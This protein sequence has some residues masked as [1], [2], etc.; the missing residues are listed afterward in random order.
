VNTLTSPADNGRVAGR[1]MNDA[2]VKRD[3]EGVDQLIARVL[4]RAHRTME[5]LNT[6]SEARAP[7]R[8]SFVR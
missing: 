1:D 4:S 6:P 8:R 5:A 7:P 2:L 3:P